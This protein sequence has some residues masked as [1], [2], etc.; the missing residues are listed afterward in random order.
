MPNGLKKKGNLN[1]IEKKR[2]ENLKK[3][4]SAMVALIVQLQASSEW[5]KSRTLMPI[6]R[7]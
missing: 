2:I 5:T 1:P 7:R 3:G 4:Q 6:S